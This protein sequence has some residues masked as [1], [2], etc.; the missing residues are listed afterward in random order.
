MNT[1]NWANVIE[2]LNPEQIEA[3]AMF[4]TA[5]GYVGWAQGLRESG[6]TGVKVPTISVMLEALETADVDAHTRNLGLLVKLIR[7][8]DGLLAE[9]A[10]EDSR[11]GLI[12]DTPN[13]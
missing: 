9:M 8:R 4:A 7:E 3:I 6:H 10:E 2:G 1:E 13:D 12:E 5:A 11:L